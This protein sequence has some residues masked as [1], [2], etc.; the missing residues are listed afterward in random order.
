[1][2]NIEIRLLITSDIHGYVFPTSF[3][4]QKEENLG[5]A[6][7]ATIIK[8]KRKE[9]H[10]I[11]I[12][13]GDF[14]QG[15][16]LTFYHHKFR[17]KMKN[18]MVT[19]ANYLKYDAVTLGNHEFNFGLSV[20]KDIMV[21]SEFPW[22]SANIINDDGGY[23]GTPYVV[24][25]IAGLRIVLLGLTTH[26]VPHWEESV[27]I[28]GLQFEDALHSAQ[29]WVNYI[30]RHEEID[31]LI[32]CY[33]G[34][35]E[36]DLQTG[37][38]VEKESGENQ[39]YAMC[40]ELEGIDVLVTGHQHREIAEKVLGKTVIQPGTKGSCLG[41]IVITVTKDEERI[42]SISHEPS[43]I[44]V[45]DQVQADEEVC[46]QLRPLYDETE[47][48][49]NRPIGVVE[50]DM[51]IHDPFQARL[52]EHPYVE[53][54]NSVQLHVSGAEISCTALFHN[55]P[56]G[57]LNHVTMRQIVAN[58]IYPNT[59]KVIELSGMDIKEALEQSATYFALKDGEISINPKFEYPKQQYYNY[60]MWEG[61]EYE[62]KISNPI[63]ERVTKLLVN[64]KPIVPE[65]KFTVVMNSY[66]ASGA[67]NFPM[68]Q[69]KS[70][71][72]EIQTDMTELI[73]QQLMDRK[74]IRA[75]CNHNW[76]VIV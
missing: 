11:L 42:V 54:I 45:D 20:L 58:Y 36:R 64:G 73:A 26:Y 61:I 41:E 10:V 55:K 24:K 34:G 16:P 32:V 8:E 31:L 3:R 13:N 75:E 17:D 74:I 44:Y 76:R 33:H 2:Q 9:G 22:L 21:Q 50:G 51:Y 30:R 49:L 65:R 48:W 52:K 37:E 18:P 38:L 47:E 56:G 12:D 46:T 35:F 5:L 69:N 60:D 67:G 29:K 70:V 72:K 57:F 66:R 25:V 14:I 28:E 1:M 63:G 39:G 23:L 59:L 71:L 27:H 4:D 15:S 62:L 40:R 7:L 6:K 53:F 68:F 43:L 19:A